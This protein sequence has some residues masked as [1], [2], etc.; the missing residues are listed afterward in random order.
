MA[1]LWIAN[2][3]VTDEA[4]YGAYVAQATE[5][6]AAHGGTFIARGGRY[7]Q[8]EGTDRP[9]NVL[10]RFPT[11]DAAIECYNSAGYQA[12][13]QQAIDSSDR[14]VVLVETDD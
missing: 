4:E 2:V 6:I 3:I 5:V 11:L 14:T 7:A 10:A 12:I 9:R 13:V 8:M 1:G